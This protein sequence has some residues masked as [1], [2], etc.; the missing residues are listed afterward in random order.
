MNNSPDATPLSI[1]KDGALIEF[2]DVTFGY[3]SH[4]PPVLGPISFT[5][6]KGQKVGVVGTSGCGK[7]TLLRLL[8]R[9]YDVQ[10]GSILINGQVSDV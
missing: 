4:L 2:R 9:F 5:V 3:H 6:P 7:S 8:L 10:G 1:D